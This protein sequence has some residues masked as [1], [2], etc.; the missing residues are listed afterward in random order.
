[1]PKVLIF[2][3]ETTNLSADFGT[4]LCV[5]Y[6]W[7]GQKAVHV[8]SVLD[9]DAFTKDPTDDRDVVRRF[10][11]VYK[12]ADLVCAFNGINFDRPYLLAKALE[13]DI[14][15]P[16][17]IPMCDPYWTV[18]SN[19]RIS[20]KNLWTVQ[21]FLRLSNSK[22]GVDGKIWK[23]ASVGHIPSVKKIIKHCRADVLTLEEA[24]LRLRPLMRAHYRLSDDLGHCR[25]CNGENLQSR[26]KNVSKTKGPQRRV[27]C[28]DCAGWD[29]RTLKEVEKYGL[30]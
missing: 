24:Y 5:G 19:L 12:S 21:K 9:T 11:D 18:K 7:L 15:V 10:L 26:G 23:R 4:L 27:Q 13:Y 2:D 6:K 17:N 25:F 20:R 8:I 14:E 28:M 1:M 22:T 30:E 29:T 3:I 16:P